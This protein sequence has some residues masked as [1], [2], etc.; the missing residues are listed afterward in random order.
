M[1]RFFL[2]KADEFTVV[3]DYIKECF[4]VPLS[5][6]GIAWFGRNG[7]FYLC[8][9]QFRDDNFKLSVLIVLEVHGINI[10][11]TILVYVDNEVF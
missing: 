9:V 3:V 5:A 10:E 7:L 8:A 6:S 2:L 11:L 1:H 4:F